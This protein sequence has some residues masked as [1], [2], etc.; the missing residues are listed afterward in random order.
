MKRLFVIF[1]GIFILFSGC[2]KKAPDIENWTVIEHIS[3]IRD[4]Q[5]LQ[6]QRNYSQQ[7]KME[8]ILNALRSLGTES[9]PEVDPDEL[10]L[11]TYTI[12]LTHTDGNQKIYQTKGDRYIRRGNGPWQQADPKKVAE[13][14]FL[15][16]SLPGD[17]PDIRHRKT[18]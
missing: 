14:N 3:V 15:L 1:F 18:R 13:L 8:Q 12:T 16:Q 6:T 9:P 2:T 4:Y 7:N 5:G 17:T 11:R 10:N